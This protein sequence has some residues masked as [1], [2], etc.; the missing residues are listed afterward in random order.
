MTVTIRPASEADIPFVMEC[1]RR[2]GYDIYVGRWEAAQ[3]RATM[4]DP[5]WH[6][7]IGLKD[8]TPA[9][10]AILSGRT[11][12]NSNLHLKRIASHDAGTGF[13]QPFM[14]A[15]IAWAFAETPAERFWLEV[16]DYN[17]RGRH[18]YAAVGMTEEGVVR[19]AYDRPDGA[20]R[21]DF[22]QMSILKSEW[23]GRRAPAPLRL[24]QATVPALDLARSI[25]FYEKLGFTL[26][27]RADHYARFEVGDGTDTFSL[28]LSGEPAVGG[29]SLY[30][31]CDDLDARVAALKA[32]GVI[33]DSEPVDQSWL[34]REAWL[35]DPAGVKL[36]LYHA[37]ENRRFPPWRLKK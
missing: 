26:I 20:G 8:G 2:P 32:E 22:I 12:R 15:I 35:T 36:C 23:Q 31:E 1:E 6:Y 25:A 10:I 3:H 29:P 19:G 14:Q 13:G 21:G 7:L 5:D 27:V 33:F 17:S 24:N 37:G 11:N 34:W 4:A 28:H 30:F 16:V 9:G 18:I